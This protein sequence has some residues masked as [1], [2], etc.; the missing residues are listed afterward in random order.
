MTFNIKQESGKGGLAGI[1]ARIKLLVSLILLVMVLSYKGFFFP[2]AITLFCICL[3]MWLRT[4]AKTFILRFSQPLVLASV[5]VLLKLF[6]GEEQLF[7]L[8]FAGIQ[9]IGYRDGL[10][11]G[12]RTGSRVIGA[13][14]VL[15][16]MSFTTPFAGF[17]GALS[18]LRIPRGFIEIVLFAH[19]YLFSLFEDAQVIYTAQKNRFGYSTL[20]SAFNSLAVLAGTLTLKA[21]TRSQN[22]ALAMIQR[23]YCGMMPMPRQ[24]PF[25]LSE[26]VGSIMFVA[27]AGIAWMI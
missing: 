3:S 21:F 13:V 26:V 2:W 18:W 9:F 10:M 20:R 11:E 19:R 25:L 1:D 5:I 15:T 12:L 8:R 6:S 27:A 23:G 16:V 14:S 17:I 4:P 24:K 7:C 22:I